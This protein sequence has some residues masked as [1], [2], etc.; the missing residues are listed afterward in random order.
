MKV[1]LTTV[2]GDLLEYAYMQV[3]IP[4]DSNSIGLFEFKFKVGT[5]DILPGYPNSATNRITSKI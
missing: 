2:Y 3:K 5:A 1:N 4:K